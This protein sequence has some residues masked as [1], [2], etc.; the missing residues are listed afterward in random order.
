MNKGAISESDLENKFLQRLISAHPQG[1]LV[2]N[3]HGLL[4]LHVAAL[5]NAP[6]TLL[7]TLLKACPKAI[8]ERVRAPNE[9]YDNYLPLHLLCTNLSDI[10]D[11]LTLIVPAHPAALAE[12]FPR[13]L[14]AHRTLF[15]PSSAGYLPAHAVARR[16]GN[17]KSAL[18]CVMEYDPKS[19]AAATDDKQ[20]VTK[21]RTQTSSNRVLTHPRKGSAW[22][23]Y[24]AVLVLICS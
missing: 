5:H 17:I 23:T 4:P 19:A 20:T 15:G 8:A 18:S 1:L 3:R 24:A 2:R 21:P 22:R 16:L 10:S 12:R 11:A 14:P 7:K 6:R 13:L 9:D